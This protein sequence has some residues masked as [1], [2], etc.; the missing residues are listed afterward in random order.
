MISMSTW[1]KMII[2][3]DHKRVILIIVIDNVDIILM[4]SI[5]YGYVDN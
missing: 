1:I 2:V 5:L 4:W 3:N